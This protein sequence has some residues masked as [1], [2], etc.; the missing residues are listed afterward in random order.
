MR[1]ALVTSE[2]MPAAHWHDG[3]SELLAAE[4]ERAAAA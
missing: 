3:D 4:L 1:I 2:R